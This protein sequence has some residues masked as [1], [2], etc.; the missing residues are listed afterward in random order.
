[1]DQTAELARVKGLIRALAERTV[2]RGCSEAE[3]MAAAAKVGELLAVYGL[4]MT[5][6]ALRDETCIERRLAID[7]PGATAIRWMFPAVL[8]F[9]GCRG[10]T[11]GR[12][13]LVLFGLEPDVQLAEWLLLVLDAALQTEAARFRVEADIP[14]RDAGAA[15]RSFRYGFAAR[16]GARLDALATPVASTPPPA[17]AQALVLAKARKL[18]DAFATLGVRLRSVRSRATVRDPGAFGRG[19]AAG[20]R[21][22]LDRP[23]PPGRRRPRL[24]G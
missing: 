24:A 18:D 9:C 16:I 20:D 12:R 14:R 1:M 7:G 11:D 15:L 19:E 22:G 17:G 10:W 6:V 4:T 5:E 3:A 13:D 2:A 23:I 8:R 21:V